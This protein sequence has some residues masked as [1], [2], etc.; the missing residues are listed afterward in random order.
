ML[1]KA[2][3]MYIQYFYDVKNLF[4]YFLN[5]F[6]PSILGFLYSKRDHAIK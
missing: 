3:E 5:Y 4:C 2:S 1:S 6:Q